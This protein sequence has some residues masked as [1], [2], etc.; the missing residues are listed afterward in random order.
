MTDRTAIFYHQDS[1]YPLMLT[2]PV[3][4]NVTEQKAYVFPQYFEEDTVYGIHGGKWVVEKLS[5]LFLTDAFGVCVFVP[6]DAPKFANERLVEEVARLPGAQPPHVEIS[7]FLET[8]SRDETMNDPHTLVI[9]DLVGMCE[10]YVADAFPN[11]VNKKIKQSLIKQYMAAVTGIATM[12]HCAMVVGIVTTDTEDANT[13][14]A[15]S[16]SG[17][18]ATTMVDEFIDDVLIDA[19]TGEIIEQPED[20]TDVVAV[21]A[22]TGEPIT[23]KEIEE[24]LAEDDDENI[25]FSAGDIIGVESDA[26]LK[27]GKEIN[28]I[29][30]FVARVQQDIT[31][32]DIKE[33]V[34][35]GNVDDLQ[36]MDLYTHGK[37]TPLDTSGIPTKLVLHP[38]DYDTIGDMYV[39]S[40]DDFADEETFEEDY[41]VF[42]K[43]MLIKK[44]GIVIGTA[45]QDFREA[46]TPYCFDVIAPNIP[47]VQSLILFGYIAPVDSVSYLP[48]NLVN[49]GDEKKYPSF[50]LNT[51]NKK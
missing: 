51:L 4:G 29:G 6:H 1:D 26:P 2:A 49:I 35:S 18:Q 40:G 42:S 12:W 46:S 30:E 32:D 9:P 25:I 3:V 14:G 11:V 50:E 13:T 23:A 39:M 36:Y 22:E 5:E 43:G 33:M 15:F 7:R 37:L 17:L 41:Y 16:I 31:R 19:N 34:G 38:L 21:N 10:A 44:N 8:V 45:L 48:Q 24:A 47:F 27:Y 20:E 28:R